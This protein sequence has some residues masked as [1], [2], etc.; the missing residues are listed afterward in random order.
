MRTIKKIIFPLLLILAVAAAVAS[1]PK[2]R[3]V[4]VPVPASPENAMETEVAAKKVY[5]PQEQ[6]LFD[7]IADLYNQVGNMKQYFVEGK[8]RL[9]NEGDEINAMET[10]FRYCRRDSMV[11]YQLGEQEIIATSSAS[12]TVNHTVKKIFI[13][14]NPDK[15]SG[16]RILLDPEQ[17]KMLREAD[18]NIT[19]EDVHPFKAIRLINDKHPLY[20][21]YRLTYD[22]SGMIRRV[23]MRSAT[24][25]EDGN[26][27]GD[28]LMSILFSKWET[29]QLSNELF[30]TDKYIHRSEEGWEPATAFAN[31]E[32]RYID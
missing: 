8:M 31:Y 29:E 1:V 14:R 24:I 22:S 18:F 26:S 30:R 17:M 27:G 6:S 28:R 23:F 16:V 20:K 15:V 11:Y 19:E 2:L 13:S 7:K 3:S 25:D 4:F 5:S 12:F 10:D 9:T 21:E 32:I